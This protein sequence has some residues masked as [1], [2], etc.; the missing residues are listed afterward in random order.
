M[1][2]PDIIVQVKNNQKNLLDD[3]VKTAET[4]VPIDED[5]E[6]WEKEHGRIVSRTAKVFSPECL[7]EKEKWNPV[8]SIIQIA[9]NRKDFNTKNKS[10]ED[11][12]ET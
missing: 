11:S 6:P 8:K 3:C 9:R 2:I 7:R 12:G 1:P 5:R 10:W 4:T